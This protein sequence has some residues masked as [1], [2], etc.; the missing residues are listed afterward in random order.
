MLSGIFVVAA[1]GAS[2]AVDT[3]NPL[4]MAE[5]GQLQCYRP[6]VE[7]RTC[8]SIA[9][10][11]QAGLKAYD[12][13]AII[14]LSASAALETHSPVTIKEGA[15]CGFIRGEDALAGILR[16]NGVIVD[17]EKAKPILERVASA[18]IP[19]SD[20][21]ICTKYEPKGSDF[22]AKIS[23]A[24]TYRPDQDVLVKWINPAEGY[25]VTP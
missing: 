10:Y 20:K 7:Q 12:N 3:A 23:I 2:S 4:A 22:T 13:K 9:S 6:N 15:V 21:E 16:V 18:M 8:Q 25:T 14:P 11:Q 5:K 24:G 1:I 19:M 17:A